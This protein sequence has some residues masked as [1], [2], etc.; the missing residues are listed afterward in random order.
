MR[1]LTP[2]RQAVLQ[3]L[4][5]SFPFFAKHCLKIKDK[6]GSIA[7]LELNA[8][9]MFI[10]DAIETQLANTG[11]VRAIILKGRQQGASTYTEG[12]LYWRTSMQMGKT[13][14]ILTHEDKATQNIFGMARRYHDLMPEA[15]RPAT[16]T[17]NA[18][19]LVFS[20]RQ[21][22]YMV[23]T[24][25]TRGTGR[26]STVQYFHGSEVAFWPAA[27]EHM[28]GVGQAVPELPGTEII[29]ESTAN[30]I[31]N[32]FHGL[33]EDAVRGRS[34]YV[35]IFVPWFWQPEYRVQP[36]A[37]FGL[38]GEEAAYADHYGL[39][40]GQMA[41]RRRKVIDDFRGDV[42]LFDQ[43]YPATPSLAFRRATANSLIPLAQVEAAMATKEV[44]GD[45]APIIMGVDVAEYGDDDT[46]IVVRQGRHVRPV[47]RHHGRGPME[48][49]GLVAVR[50]DQI[51][52][53]AINVDCT[54]VGS[55]VADRLLELGYPVNR[56]HFGERA[57]EDQLYGIRR[58]E[59]WGELARWLA[60]SPCELPDDRALASDLVGPSYTYDASRRLKLESKEQMKKRGLRSPDSGDA[61]AL[62][63]AVR[64]VPRPQRR[65]TRA[66]NWKA[67]R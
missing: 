60:D 28:A 38:D 53:V 49:A 5:N 3:R 7:P 27:E 46:A 36:P 17:A 61:L 22:R 19:E 9:Q 43:E 13:A 39:D 35:P 47:E 16:S 20:A 26:S 14:Y 65:P 23:G 67:A 37:D 40:H 42:A 21:S 31:G 41:W 15:M 25:G 50:A 2:E 51:K 64:I 34:Q 62:T 56:V 18:N 12:R 4:Q 33:W 54:G 59:M 58:D 55:G 32:V 6:S 10:H 63:F 1:S 44:P 45:Q 57:I 30:G 48:V 66:Y 52:P 11:R 24:A 8:A 29:L